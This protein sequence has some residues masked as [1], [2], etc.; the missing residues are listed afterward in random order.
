MKKVNP[1]FDIISEKIGHPI[2]IV[3]LT[4]LQ[5]IAFIVWIATGFSTLFY[6]IFHIILAIVT[7]LVALIIESSEKLDTRAIQIKL[8]E[9]I[10]NMPQLDN[11]K[12]GIERKL[13]EKRD[14]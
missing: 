5:L 9:I 1:I 13:K 8:D 4:L 2:T 11:K 6:E 7:L 3:F 14:N 10:K 12:I